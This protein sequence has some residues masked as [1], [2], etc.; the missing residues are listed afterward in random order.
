MKTFLVVRGMAMLASSS[1]VFRAADKAREESNQGRG[2]AKRAR[3][4]FEMKASEA[5]RP[6]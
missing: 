3:V 6:R 2:D 5:G 4:A 1:V